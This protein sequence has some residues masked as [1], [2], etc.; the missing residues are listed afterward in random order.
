MNVYKS[1]N[2]IIEYIDNHLDE[3]IDFDKLALMLG[4]NSYTLQRI[5]SLLANV[6]LTDYIRKR[7][8][9]TAGEEYYYLKEVIIKWI[10]NI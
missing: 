8:L 3:K 4:A 5:F 1:L 9:S 6:T 10:L 7:R 2:E